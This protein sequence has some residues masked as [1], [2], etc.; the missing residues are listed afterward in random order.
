[1]QA[2]SKYLQ[3]VKVVP[4]EAGMLPDNRHRG[5]ESVSSVLSLVYPPAVEAVL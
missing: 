2:R 1:M 4:S 5:G 3:L